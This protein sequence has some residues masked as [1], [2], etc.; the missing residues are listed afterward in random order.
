M[1]CSTMSGLDQVSVGGCVDFD[2]CAEAIP[3][4][5]IGPQYP[6]TDDSGDAQMPDEDVFSLAAPD[7][8]D[9]DATT[10]SAGVDAT[11]TTAAVDATASSAG[12]DVLVGAATGPPLLGPPH[13]VA[14]LN[15]AGLDYA[16]IDNPGQWLAS[17]VP[18][19]CGPIS[20]V[21]QN[22]LHGT[23]DAPLFAG[24]ATGNP[25]T[26]TIGSGLAPGTYRV[27]LY[28]AEIFWGPG[29]RANVEGGAGKRVFDIVLEGQTVLKDF[30]I[31]AESGGCMA[32]RS[33][34]SGVP[35]VKTFEI[36]VNDGV[37]DILMP[38]KKDR[39]AIS[40]LEVFGP[41]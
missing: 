41:L 39:A 2:T 31:F 19:V 4:V 30:D 22:P 27:R 16:G 40:A 38:A 3:D 1:E 8:S 20:S 18:G 15:I 10:A 13:L 33:V 12:V 37:L 34:G 35:V 28:F 32:S 7:A 6:A 5:H 14:R 21:T 36:P 24:E 23:R 25:V 9:V 26:C 17:P 11:A 29:C